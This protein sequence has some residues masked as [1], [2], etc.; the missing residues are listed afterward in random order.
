M[1]LGGGPRYVPGARPAQFGE[2][3]DLPTH[4]ART[5]ALRVLHNELPGVSESFWLDVFPSFLEL[6]FLAMGHQAP[7]TDPG[8]I[9]SGADAWDDPPAWEPDAWT[10]PPHV[11]AGARQALRI[12]FVAWAD[13]WQLVD[14]WIYWR[15]LRR[16]WQ[17]W[18]G[19]LVACDNCLEPRAFFVLTGSAAAGEAL[20]FE[21][22]AWAAGV[23][24]WGTWR[25]RAEKGFRE[26]LTAY[27]GVV[28]DRT[29]PTPAPENL[30]RDVCWLWH[31][32]VAEKSWREILVEKLAPNESDP[33]NVRVN[34]TRVAL[35]IDLT[36]R[37]AAE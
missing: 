27:K 10:P 13:R 32:E 16:A 28:E 5:I 33:D 20:R 1:K 18:T 7:L 6:S 17:S 19:Q 25:K 37:S 9:L 15:A 8:W 35:L 11:W 36:L 30:E 12:S 29:K 34:A 23:E 14:R 22:K 21:A 24:S 4:N 31:H 26:A 2:D 3:G